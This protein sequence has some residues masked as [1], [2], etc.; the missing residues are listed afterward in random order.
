[1]ITDEEKL[2][3]VERELRTRRWNYPKWVWSGRITQLHADTE[4]ALMDAIADDYRRKI[5]LAAANAGFA[6]M[7]GG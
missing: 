6:A 7:G 2:A 5:A 1:M 3:C 4:I